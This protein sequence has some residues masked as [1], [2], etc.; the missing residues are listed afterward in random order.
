MECSYFINEPEAV[1]EGVTECVYIIYT[2]EG[3]VWPTH[4]CIFSEFSAAVCIENI[5]IIEEERTGDIQ[6]VSDRGDIDEE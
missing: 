2:T 4:T 3:Q 6:L 5:D 1:C